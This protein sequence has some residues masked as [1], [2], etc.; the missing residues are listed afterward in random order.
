MRFSS[1]EVE[2]FLEPRE[3]EWVDTA[4]DDDGPS[5]SLLLVWI[6]LGGVDFL[7][8]FNRSAVVDCIFGESGERA[9]RSV[10]CLSALSRYIIGGEM[11]SLS[12]SEPFDF[13]SGNCCW[14]LF[15]VSRK[16]KMVRGTKNNFCYISWWKLA[17][18]PFS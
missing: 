7:E 4:F 6:F 9:V 18:F 8:S 13:Q 5:P 14:E 12:P 2:S 1:R 10:R 15:V 11:S 3:G 16:E 17:A